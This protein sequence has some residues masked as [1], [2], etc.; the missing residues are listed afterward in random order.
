[1]LI[2]RLKGLFYLL[3]KLYLDLYYMLNIDMQTVDL[4]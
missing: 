4:Y 2:W 3:N 1:M